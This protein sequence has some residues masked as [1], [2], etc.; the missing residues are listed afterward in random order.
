[1]RTGSTTRFIRT[2]VW[3]AAA[4]RIS[5]LS[6]NNFELKVFKPESEE[7]SGMVARW[8]RGDSAPQQE[9]IDVVNKAYPEVKTIFDMILW[10]LLDS[11]INSRKK[12]QVLDKRLHDAFIVPP[13]FLRELCYA[14]TYECSGDSYH[15]SKS[16]ESV[17]RW[18]PFYFQENPFLISF[19]EKI[20]LE[21]YELSKSIPSTASKI[22]P[23]VELILEYARRNKEYSLLKSEIPVIYLPDIPQHLAPGMMEILKKA[24]RE[25]RYSVD[26][27]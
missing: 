11:S 18:A 27:Y 2:Q 14:R 26:Y 6:A 15:H 21:I 24:K 16:I 7:A 22:Y 25:Y 3:I 1:M 17:Y 9:S 10:D 13:T 20:I 4:L 23:D 8:A 5:E 19:A 12:I